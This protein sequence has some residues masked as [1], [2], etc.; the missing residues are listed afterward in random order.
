MKAA[1]ISQHIISLPT[2]DY[3]SENTKLLANRQFRMLFQNM[4]EEDNPSNVS[5]TMVPLK[6]EIDR[7][8]YRIYQQHQHQQATIIEKTPIEYIHKND[9]PYRSIGWVRTF[10]TLCQKLLTQE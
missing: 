7:M 2:D 9:M 10:F 8:F 5:N 6:K 3:C 1:E 4:L